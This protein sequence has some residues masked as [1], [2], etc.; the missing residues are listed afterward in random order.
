MI[1]KATS[2]LVK[3]KDQGLR[4]ESGESWRGTIRSHMAELF[5]CPKPGDW[6]QT[7]YCRDVELIFSGGHI[8]LAAAFKGP[9]LMLGLYKRSYSYIYTVLTSDSTLWKQPQ[10]WCGPPE[11]E[12]DT[13]GLL[14]T[15]SS[16]AVGINCWEL[17]QEP[18]QS[19]PKYGSV[20]L[21]AFKSRDLHRLV[22]WYRCNQE[23]Y[24]YI[25]CHHYRTI[26][27]VYN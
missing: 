18:S 27:Y 6:A 9:N 5:S 14:E 16:P 3:R 24:K 26:S 8:N 7:A 12:F 2:S 20:T 25:C 1:P 11:N 21:Y 23:G 22:Y 15:T 10:S 13:P 19:P 4:P 17:C